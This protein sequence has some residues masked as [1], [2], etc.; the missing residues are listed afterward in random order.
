MSPL[1]RWISLRHLLQEGGRSGLTL[2]GVAIGVAV[3]VSIRLA[4]GSALGSFA[5][6]VDCVAGRANLQVLSDSDGFDE[7]IF[8]TLRALPGVA[9]AA[10]VVQTYVLARP[11]KTPGGAALTSGDRSAYSETLLILG[12][13]AFSEGPFQRYE[14]PRPEERSALFRFMADPRAVAVTRTLAARLGLRVGD[15]LTVLS[16]GRPVTLVVQL[17][18]ESQELQHAMGGNVVIADISTAQELFQRFGR[19]DRV[20]LIVDPTRRE[21]VKAAIRP[22]LPPNASVEQ[23]QGR[24]R[25]VENM[26]GA[27]DL[28]ITALS[29]IALFV[30]MFLVFNTVSMAALRRRSEVGI[31]RSLGVT[32]RQVAVLFLAE[33]LLYG[34]AGSL[35][36]LLLGTLLAR[37]TLGT[38]AQTVTELYLVVEATRVRPD[39][40]TYLVAFLLGA[41]MSLAASLAPAL[42]AAQTSPH[43][44]TRQGTLIEA[45]PLPVAGWAAA[46][47]V[48]LAA[49]AGTAFWTMRLRAPA[50]GFLSAALVLAGFSL[51]T[52]AISLGVERAAGPALRRL[53]GIEAALGARYLRDA[54]ARTSVVAA[55]LMVSVGMMVGLAI[56]VSSFRN[57]VNVWVNQTLRGDLYVEPVGR[58]VTGSATVLAPEIAATARRLPGVAAVDTYR[59]IRITY[60]GK[61]AFI[62]AIDFEVQARHGRLQFMNGPTAEVLNRARTADEVVVTESFAFRHGV[63][64]G[65][66]VRLDTPIGPRA[67]RIAGVF[68]DYS[69]DTGAILM[70]R[71]LFARL[72]ADDRTESLAI[73]VRPGQRVDEV[74]AQFIAAL[75]NRYVLYVT[76]NQALRRRVL[77][78][79]DETF[80][81]TYALQAIAV[82]VAVLGVITTLTALILQRGREIGILRAAGALRSQIRKMVLVESALI[83]LIGSLLGC[84]CGLALALLLIFVIN[85]LF[86]GWTIRLSVTPWVFLQAVGLIVPTALLAGVSPARLAAGRVAA[87]A[88]RVE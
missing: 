76:P 81:I 74:R 69:T 40:A 48:L 38:V 25:Q 45:R 58:R 3:F 13:D 35:L 26:L 51:L 68:Y 55:A 71:R 72:W 61:I 52:P 50:G 88:M 80:R 83:G 59:A 84:L 49:A 22:L 62:A 28:S 43:E 20:D 31:L 5:E 54:V 9:A 56:M 19:L 79:F 10:P 87:E 64:A 44:V 18:L 21:A 29:F 57:T 66:H 34:T 53:F 23:P 86:F 60:G 47:L 78:V 15:P 77:T 16:A 8:P 73:Y 1:F 4:N 2:L 39:A 36:G 41:G 24:T 27:F 37:L 46:G 65:D 17:I 42:E 6:T 11:G 75:G 70:D 12:V 82:V 14:P 32:R 7:R 33:G 30:S 67:L 85:R 63:R